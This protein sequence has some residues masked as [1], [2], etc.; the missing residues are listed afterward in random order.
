[1]IMRGPKSILNYLLGSGTKN[2]ED[3]TRAGANNRLWSFIGGAI[4]GAAVGSLAFPIG[5]VLGFF[6]GGLLGS[7]F[8]YARS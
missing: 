5:T 7:T 2:W 1:M 8:N 4:V 3:T 6:I